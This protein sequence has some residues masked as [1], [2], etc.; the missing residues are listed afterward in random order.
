MEMKEEIA[1]VHNIRSPSPKK[2]S[3]SRSR[4]H[5]GSRK[6]S[7]GHP[8]TEPGPAPPIETDEKPK[9]RE[10]W[11]NTDQNESLDIELPIHDQIKQG[12]LG[13]VEN[14][15]K[16]SDGNLKNPSFVFYSHDPTI[17]DEKFMKT[18][19]RPS[20]GHKEKRSPSYRKKKRHS[21]K[22]RDRELLEFDIPGSSLNALE[23]VD[24]YLREYNKDEVVTL[25]GELEINDA[26]NNN[27]NVKEVRQKQRKTRRK[28]REEKQE[29]SKSRDVSP[30]VFKSGNK[31]SK[32]VKSTRPTDLSAMLESLESNVPYHDQYIDNPFS[33]PSPVTSP[34]DDRI[35]PFGTRRSDKIYMQGGG[36]FTAVSRDAMLQPEGDG[37]RYLRLGDLTPLDVAL[38]IQKAWSSGAMA[39]HG[40]LGGLS[41]MHLLLISSSDGMDAD[42]LSFHAIVTMP[43]VAAYFFFCI[44]CLVSVLDRLDIPSINLSEGLQSYFQAIVLVILYSACLLVCTAARWYDELM[45]YH[46]PVDVNHNHTS[47]NVT[48]EPAIPEF[49]HTWTHF[50][51]WRAVLAILGLVYFVISNPQDLVYAN[52]YKLLQYKQSLPPIG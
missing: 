18:L 23:K 37:D 40:I 25:S 48:A 50:S 27:G 35:G 49:Y 5:S 19:S 39:C 38:A 9:S 15:I 42:H 11:I 12:I 30:K 14:E 36:T 26:E 2:K 33:S 47:H 43:Y 8:E 20:S 51:I 22:H 29:S 6:L 24:D 52:I 21:S 31:H 4:S 1:E 16:K 32:P 44:L 34:N 10:S 41:L 28:V 17:L 45:V 3:K 7:N 46:Y 13:F